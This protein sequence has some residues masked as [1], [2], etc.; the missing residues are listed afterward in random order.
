MAGIPEA[1]EAYVARKTAEETALR[2][3]IAAAAERFLLEP[4][5]P[6]AR[7]ALRDALDAAI[8]YDSEKAVG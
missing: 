8:Q 3:K 2:T 7:R 6:V 5:S 1:I 4:F